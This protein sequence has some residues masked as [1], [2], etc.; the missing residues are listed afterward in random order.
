MIHDTCEL[1]LLDSRLYMNMKYTLPVYEMLLQ[2]YPGVLHIST[3]RVNVHFACIRTY[4]CI[5]Y[6]K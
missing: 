6:V 4:L 1:F 2:L 5:L 3:C